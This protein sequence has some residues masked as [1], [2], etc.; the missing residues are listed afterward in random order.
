[1]LEL[2]RTDLGITP[3][4]TDTNGRRCTWFYFL[5]VPKGEEYYILAVGR[6]EEMK[7]TFE[8]ITSGVT[9]SLGDD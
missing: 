2:A 8:E 6:R 1:M 5:E 9:L 3:V 4:F 7:Y